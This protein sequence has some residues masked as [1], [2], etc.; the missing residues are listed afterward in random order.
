MGIFLP[1]IS[2]NVQ[3]ETPVKT[4]V[5]KNVITGLVPS[6][7]AIAFIILGLKKANKYL[8]EAYGGF[9]AFIFPFLSTIQLFLNPITDLAKFYVIFVLSILGWFLIVIILLEKAKDKELIENALP[10]IKK[11][12]TILV[13]IAIWFYSLYLIAINSSHQIS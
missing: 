3:L 13:V 9:I 6:L 1:L 10:Q 11:F 8:L 2:M 5:L 7:F 12:F 4:Q